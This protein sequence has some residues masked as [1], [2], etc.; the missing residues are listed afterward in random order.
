M[1][2]IEFLPF[3]PNEVQKPLN[4]TTTLLD[5]YEEPAVFAHEATRTGSMTFEAK[6]VVQELHCNPATIPQLRGEI[7]RVGN[8]VTNTFIIDAENPDGQPPHTIGHLKGVKLSPANLGVGAIYSAIG[9]DRPYD[10]IETNGMICKSPGQ[11]EEELVADVTFTEDQDGRRIVENPTVR[12]NGREHIN[13][14]HWVFVPSRSSGGIY[15]PQYRQFEIAPQMAGAGLELLVGPLL[16]RGRA[17]IYDG[18]GALKFFPELLEPGEEVRGQVTLY[19]LSNAPYGGLLGQFDIKLFKE[20]MEIAELIDVAL[21]F[22]PEPRIME[23]IRTA[24]GGA[25]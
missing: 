22:Y 20:E 16:G 14:T 8:R 2:R 6:Y 12:I 13:G 19:D 7:Q 5:I 9:Y 10:L 15:L 1:P 23:F 21:G 11:P 18:T 24:L 25:S 4:L 3:D 17:A